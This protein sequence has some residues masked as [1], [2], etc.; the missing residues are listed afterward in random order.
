[1]RPASGSRGAVVDD[2]CWFLFAH[3]QA[4]PAS[5]SEPREIFGA[6]AAS[7]DPCVAP[8]V[9]AGCRLRVRVVFVVELMIAPVAA[10]HRRRMR[11][12]RLVH[13]RA[14]ALRR[15]EHA[16]RVALVDSGADDLLRHDEHGV[17][18]HR[19]F[20]AHPQVAPGMTAS[21]LIGALDVHD[22]HVWD[23]RRHEHQFLT[24]DRRVDDA[25]A[26]IRLH[27]IG[28]EKR[29]RGNEL[30][31][32][33]PREQTQRDGEVRVVLDGYRIG[34]PAL[35]GAPI[36]MAQAGADIAPPPRSDRAHPAGADELI[37]EDVGDGA[38]QREIAFA[39]ADDLVPGREWNQ[40]L[41]SQ[42]YSHRSA[43]GN[44]PRDRVAHAHELA[45]YLFSNF[46]I[47][48][49]T[50]ALRPSFASLLWNSSCWSSRSMASA[51][52]NG[53]SPP[54]WTERFMLPTAFAALFGVVN[55][56]A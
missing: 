5:G 38:D 52:E 53:T 19:A 31:A 21:E 18:R 49:S 39:P 45:Y 10:L 8:R 20:F 2:R 4:A 32:E 46:A 13:D 43:V 54:D 48:L 50:Y 36:A 22:R 56:L 24:V 23:D 12:A 26:R 42:P 9:V 35:G 6:P 17:A 47:R 11:S 28:A 1:M 55:C 44:V 16:I 29:F 37:E 15:H 30:R 51:S 7:I 3:L 33:G 41:E 27:E 34:L 40:R 14:H 25:K